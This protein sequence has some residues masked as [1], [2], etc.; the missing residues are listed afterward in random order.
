MTAAFR[1]DAP[2]DE[3]GDRGISSIVAKIAAKRDQTHGERIRLEALIR[4]H[5]ARIDNLPVINAGMVLKDVGEAVAQRLRAEKALDLE[6]R[7]SGPY[8]LANQWYLSLIEKGK[9]EDAGTWSILSLFG[10]IETLKIEVERNGRRW[11]VPMPNGIDEIKRMLISAH[12]EID[13]RKRKD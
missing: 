7:I 8:G 1:Q 2:N 13:E 12:D 6:T 5:S 3:A 10:D 4:R 9:T 11:T